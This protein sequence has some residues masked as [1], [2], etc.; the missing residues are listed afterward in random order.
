M[1]TVINMIAMSAMSMSLTACFNSGGGSGAATATPEAGVLPAPTTPTPTI[2]RNLAQAMEAAGCTFAEEADGLSVTCNG[3]TGKIYNGTNGAQGLQGIQGVKG[4]K[5]DTGAVGATGAQGA[6]GIQGQQGVAGAQGAQGIQ[7]V[8][9]DK[10]DKGDQGL[11]GIQGIQGIQGPAGASAPQYILRDSSGT[12]LSSMEFYAKEVRDTSISSVAV[13]GN[14]VYFLRIKG[15]PYL[16][17]YY[18][19]YTTTD[20]TSAQYV[21]YAATG[22]PLQFTSKNCT[23][24][25]YL[26]MSRPFI[27]VHGNLVYNVISEAGVTKM[28]KTSGPLRGIDAHGSRLMNSVCTSLSGSGSITPAVPVQEIS[29]TFTIPTGFNGELVEDL[30]Q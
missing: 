12:D 15:T 14:A 25:P 11:Q 7:G 18:Y 20:A 10:G 27:G 24:Q 8:K 21:R 5:G 4:D 6:Q 29:G 1:K 16:V 2:D 28:Y 26:A 22:A 17:V 30:A 19:P 3:T 13:G 23:G 9:G